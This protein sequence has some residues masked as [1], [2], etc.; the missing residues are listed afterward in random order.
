[1]SNICVQSSLLW[2]FLNVENL[3]TDEVS[4]WLIENGFN[5]CEFNK[6]KNS[7]TLKYPHEL[8]FDDK[9]YYKVEFGYPSDYLL[10]RF[11]HNQRLVCMFMHHEKFKNYYSFVKVA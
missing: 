1:M 8:S 3:T 2:K 11:D 7:T 10:I 5:D 9:P 4:S 6:N